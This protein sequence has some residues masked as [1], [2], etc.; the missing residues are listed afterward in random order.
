MLSCGLIYENALSTIQIE[1]MQ[2]NWLCSIEKG[3][4]ESFVS[5]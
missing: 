3:L 2:E 5:E 1:W 4:E